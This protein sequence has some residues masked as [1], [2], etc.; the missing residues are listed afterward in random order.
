ME[1]TVIDAVHETQ[2]QPWQPPL[3]WTL[4]SGTPAAVSAL[5][6]IAARSVLSDTPAVE[7]LG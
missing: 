5:V 1:S 7:P 3:A 2:G 6:R 4:K